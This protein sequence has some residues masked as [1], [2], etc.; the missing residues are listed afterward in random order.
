MDIHI[1][2]VCNTYAFYSF[3]F[4][5]GG[6][7]L[8]GTSTRQFCHDGQETW[9]ASNLFFYTP[10]KINTEPKKKHPIE[11][12]EKSFEPNLHDF[13]FN[14]LIFS[15]VFLVFLGNLSASSQGQKESSPI[16]TSDGFR[17]WRIHPTTRSVVRITHIYK[18][19]IHTM[20]KVDCA[21]PKRWLS[22]G[23]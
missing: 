10:L 2:N 14:M 6:A 3:L 4:G 20:V 12:R 1:L 11:M 23:P 21:T 7:E 16:G 19:F 15:R 22:K 17:T 18:P 8:F 5:G 13:G 9:E